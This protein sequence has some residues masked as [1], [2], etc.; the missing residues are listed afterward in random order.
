MRVILNWRLVILFRE[1][2]FLTGNRD[3]AVWGDVIMLIGYARVSTDDQVLDRDALAK[4]GVE[5]DRVYGEQI[6]GARQ[7][8]PQLAECLK[9]CR[10]GDIL[11]VWRLDRLGRSVPDLIRIMDDLQKRGIGFRSLCESI[12]TTTAAGKMIFHMLAAFAEFERNLIS[13]RTRAGLKAAR[14]RGHRGGKP[15]TVTPVKLKAALAMLANPTITSDEAAAAIGVSRASLYRAMKKSRE[16]QEAK[17]LGKAARLA[18]KAA[19]RV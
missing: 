2:R 7:Y 16:M 10:E 9:S 6:G 13:E 8:R 14:A 12:D 5:P 15:S 4:A 3:A 1:N 19:N 11:V 18:K 17:R